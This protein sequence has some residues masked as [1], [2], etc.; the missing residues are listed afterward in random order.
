MTNGSTSVVKF[1]PSQANEM[2]ILLADSS[3]KQFKFDYV[4]GPQDSQACKQPDLSD[5]R[6]YKQLV[7]E[8]EIQ[9]TEE[10]KTGLKQES[11]AIATFSAEPPF[12]TTKTSTR[13]NGENAATRSCKIEASVTTN[14]QFL[15]PGIS[16]PIIE[17]NYLAFYCRK[18]TI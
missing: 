9:L 15:A 7:G 1:N 17:Q 13:N 11:K 16:C 6:K 14:L 10:R 12:L 3:K 18:D 8:L 4:F 5:L 2:H